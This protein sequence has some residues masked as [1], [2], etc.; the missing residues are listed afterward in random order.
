MARLY[1]RPDK[2]G[3]TYYIDFTRGGRRV[4]HSLETTKL[5]E[6]KERR[7]L[8]LAEKVGTQWGK[9]S[10]DISPDAFWARYEKWAAVRKVPVSLKTE[11]YHWNQFLRFAR[12]KTL[13]A[14]EPRDIEDFVRY[15]KNKGLSSVTI[16]DQLTCLKNLYNRARELELYTGP[17]PVDEV[18]RL[19]VEK[20]PPRFLNE[21]QIEAVMTEAAKRSRDI[22]L[23]FSLGV[24]AGLRTN[25]IGNAKWEWLDFEQGTLTVQR[26]VDGSFGTKGKR[27][28]TI[29][30]HNRLRAILEPL[31]KAGGYLIMPN[32]EGSGKW[33]TR[34]EPKRAFKT[35][36]KAAGVEWCSPHILRHTFA[37]QLVQKGVSLYKV[38]R[39]LGHASIT[40]TQIYAHL[41]PA[42]D[43]INAF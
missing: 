5:K 34:Y 14:V 40:T 9:P 36:S 31:R 33:R 19:P 35:V 27:F 29:P 42:D 38:S 10:Q 1:R 4:R 11:A 24:F 26:A 3:G 7:D 32:K 28:R 8:V 16:N 20:S 15:R 6:A 22:Y 12:P 17:N 39:W 13:G 2:P 23:F 18:K 21:E 25:E 43:D 30:L 41:A 37:S